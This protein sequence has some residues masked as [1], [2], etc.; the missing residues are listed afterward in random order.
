MLSVIVE[1]VLL[2]IIP[3]TA[4]TKATL[5]PVL[6]FLLI[7]RMIAMWDSPG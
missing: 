3:A 2:L 5:R 6:E 4:S 1:S 7:L